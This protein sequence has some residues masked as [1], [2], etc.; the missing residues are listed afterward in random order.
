MWTTL[1]AIT[2][3]IAVALSFAAIVTD[4]IKGG[5]FRL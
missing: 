3:V 2:F 5:K 4:T 1:F